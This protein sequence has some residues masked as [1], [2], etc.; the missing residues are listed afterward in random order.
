MLKPT[1]RIKI[2]GVTIKEHLKDI[3]DIYGDVSVRLPNDI[4]RR[5]QET[6]KNKNG[7][8]NIQ[9]V[10]F[11]YGYLAVTAFLYRYA[12]HV[13]IERGTYVQNSDIK[14]LLGYSKTTK[15]IDKIIKK[16]GV[17]DA[18][19]FT[20]T[21]TSYPIHFDYTKDVL[22][23]N[24]YLL[25]YTKSDDDIEEETRV[26]LRTIVKN[27]N[28]E[29]KEPLFLFEKYGDNDYGTVYD[30]RKTHEIS[31]LE[32]LNF[33]ES[34]LLNNIDLLIYAYIKSRCKG[35]VNHT[36]PMTLYKMI[37]EIG[38]DRSSFYE[39][40]K[41]LKGCSLI[42]VTHKEWRAPVEGRQIQMNSNEYKWLGL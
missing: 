36:K 38:I 35:Y 6:I 3:H 29:I 42:D 19:G 12:T 10:A 8:T 7:S 25:N 27:R 32:V 5:L 33:I 1:L 9:Q 17:L 24:T 13:N 40:I 15:S 26:L 14:M 30:I 41:V 31:V 2:G 39:H 4:F 20:K 11:S 28:Y 22:L 18:M 34:D 23:N 37:A 21:T 16:D